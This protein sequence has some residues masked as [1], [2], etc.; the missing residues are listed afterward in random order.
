MPMP[1]FALGLPGC[2]TGLPVSTPVAATA[3][4]PPASTSVTVITA[5]F[6]R[7][8]SHENTPAAVRWLASCLWAAARSCSPRVLYGSVMRSP[9]CFA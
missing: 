3:I 1:A 2:F 8:D 9:G 6:S 4:A 7:R 5:A